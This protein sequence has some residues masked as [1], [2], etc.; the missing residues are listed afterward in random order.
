MKVVIEDR[1]VCGIPVLD[2]YET[3]AAKRPIVIMLHRGG[4]RKEENIE[5]AYEY[6]KKEFYVT[7]F[8][9]Y[10]HGELRD[11]NSQSGE[12]TIE[13][14]LKWYL[15]TSMYL[16]IIINSY[17]ECVYADFSRIGLIGVSMGACTIYY[18]ILK[19]RNPNVKAAV[20]IIGSPSWVSFVRRDLSSLPVEGLKYSE[21]DISEME[22]YVKQNEPL[23]YAKGFNDFPLLMLNGEKDE[24]MPIS[25]VRQAYDGLRKNY[26]DKQ[27]IKLFEFE[28]AGHSTAP[29]MLQLGFQW[30]RKYV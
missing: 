4:G 3:N 17:G 8:D 30:L 27:L 29:E 1:K 13:K 26:T 19:E 23:S 21:E 6:A 24:L 15:E 10:G 12:M 28:G 18:N 7:L 5:I 11:D 20:S 16:N 25:N 2:I 14:A 9:A 22:R